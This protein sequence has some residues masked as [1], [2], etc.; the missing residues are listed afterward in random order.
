MLF[1]ISPRCPSGGQSYLHVA[2]SASLHSL[3][4]FK[5]R[6]PDAPVSSATANVPAQVLSNFFHGWILVSLQISRASHHKA[7]RAEPALLGV[8]L[9]KG[10]HHRRELSIAGEPFDGGNVVSLGLDGQHRAGIDR[11]AV[12]HHRASPAG[13]AVTNLFG[14]G[15]RQPVAQGI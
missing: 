15:D 11:L 2:M 7:G 9:D 14:A 12:N 8:V 4:G 10:L 6:M 1:P 13:G 5:D 3:R